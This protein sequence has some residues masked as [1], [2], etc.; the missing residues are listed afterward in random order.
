MLVCSVC[1]D[2]ALT[3]ACSH[4]HTFTRS[5][6]Y[7]YTCTLVH[8]HTCTLPPN[9]AQVLTAAHSL[10]AIVGLLH[11]AALCP[12]SDERS[13]QRAAALLAGLTVAVRH[14]G[15][16]AATAIA[17][18]LSS[19]AHSELLLRYVQRV[20]AYVYVYVY[21]YMCVFVCVCVCVCVCICVCVCVCMYSIAL[22]LYTSFVSRL[23]SINHTAT[24]FY[25]H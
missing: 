6:L 12:L 8:L 18:R 20:F 23:L 24:M 4:F 10:A 9:D 17:A 2:R 3:F 16:L 1:Y 22:L 15:R 5:H 11:E 19:N 7:L 13:K 21:M 25:W 14:A